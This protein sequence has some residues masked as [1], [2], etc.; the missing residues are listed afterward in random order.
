[1]FLLKYKN[2][3]ISG[4]FSII[5]E[6]SE[7]ILLLFHEYDDAERYRTLLE[8]DDYSG[9]EVTEYDDDVMFK[10]IDSMDCQ[11]TIVN[12]YDLVIPPT[13]FK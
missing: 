13:I 9:L 6:N 10:M 12:P 11:Y 5:N 7:K 3:E 1:M 8:A 2:T 4:A